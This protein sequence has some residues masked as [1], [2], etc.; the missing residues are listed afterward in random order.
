MSIGISRE[1]AT[2]SEFATRAQKLLSRL[3]ESESQEYV[4]TRFVLLR[5]LGFIYCVAFSTLVFQVEPLLGKSGLLPAQSWLNAIAADFW[6]LPS[7]FWISASDAMLASFAWIGLAL[8]LLVLLGFANAPLLGA[9]WFL[10]MSFVHVGQD[11]YGFGWEIMTL[12]L[13]FLAIFLPPALDPRP[14]RAEKPPPVAVIWLVRWMLFRTMYGAGLIKLRG[15]SCWSDLTCL[16]YHYETQPNPH[17]LSWYFH[18]FP[19]WVNATGVLFN[20]FVELIVP[21]FYFA[22]RRLRH[23]AGALTILFQA[24][25]IASGNLA[26]LNW[27]TI[28]IAF[29]CFDDTFWRRLRLPAIGLHGSPLQGAR[30]LRGRDVT[31]ALLVLVVVVLSI[32]PTLNMLSPRQIMNTSFDRLHLVNTYGAFGTIGRERPELVIEGS[33]D[34]DPSDATWQEY[35]FWCK[36]GPIDEPPCLITPYHY[37]VDWQIWFA[38]MSEPRKHLWLVHLVYKLLAGEDVG[39]F[40][41]HNPFPDAPPRWVRISLYRY[42]FTDDLSEGWWRRE[43]QKTWFGPVGASDLSELRGLLEDRALR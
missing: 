28:V 18:H 15:D 3:S 10:Y 12:E 7:I 5:G 21:F 23:A 17:P 33:N 16:N 25:L 9:L 8:A 20:H 40:F 32:A 11:F 30:G 27:L 41:E 14:L 37:R 34:A 2:L 31:T 39:V 38:A 1:G 19:E 29:A 6:D 4:W 26:Y 42:E 43:R 24:T 22:P 36:P 13:G 35:D